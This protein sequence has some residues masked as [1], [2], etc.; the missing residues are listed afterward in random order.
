MAENGNS[1]EI[2]KYRLPRG[3][4]KTMKQDLLESEKLDL[5]GIHAMAYKT[6]WLDYVRALWAQ[7]VDHVEES[8][9][10]QKPAE[11]LE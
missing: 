9:N 1:V 7:V 10:H 4:F 8:T 11:V 5:D 2:Q 3:A 6:A